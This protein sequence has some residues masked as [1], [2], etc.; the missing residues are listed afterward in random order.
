MTIVKIEKW[1]YERANA[2]GIARCTARWG[3]KDAPHYADKARQEDNRTAEVAAALCELAVA[4]LTNRYWHGHVWHHTEHQK[5]RDL[6]DVGYNIEVRRLRTRD[7]VAIRRHQ[8]DKSNLIVFAARVIGAE[9]DSVE[10]YGYIN[11]QSGWDI[12]SPSDYDPENTHLVHISQLTDY[13]A[14][15]LSPSMA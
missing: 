11:Q 13:V 2:V 1:E 8:N 15:A 4:K 12:G 10:V 9:M 3:S 6:P 7:T 14:K 5:Y